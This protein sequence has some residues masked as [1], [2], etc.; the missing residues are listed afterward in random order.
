MPECDTHSQAIE[1]TP[2]APKIAP[3]QR[4]APAS[5]RR[6]TAR[7]ACSRTASM[8]GAGRLCPLC[9]SAIRD[10][11]PRD[12]LQTPGEIKGGVLHFRDGSVEILH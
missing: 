7:R 9:E 4:S 10:R 3:E 8:L 5:P 11:G 12:R 6:R 1:S 2:R